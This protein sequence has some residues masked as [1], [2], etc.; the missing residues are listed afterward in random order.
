MIDDV[1]RV[2]QVVLNKN[3]YGNIDPDDMNALAKDAQLKVFYDLPSEIYRIKRRRSTTGI[4]DALVPFQNALDVF[5]DREPVQRES[6]QDSSTGFSDYFV[7]PLD[8][9]HLESVWYRDNTFVDEIDKKKGR[10]VLSNPNTAPTVQY[11]VFEKRGNNI[12]LFPET[13]GLTISNGGSII[14]SDV[15]IYY[16]R[17]PK[18]PKWTFISVNNKAVF[19][20]GDSSYQDFELPE[21][22]FRRLL[23]EMAFLSGISLREEEVAKYMNQEQVDDVQKQNLN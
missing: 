17:K 13:I 21:Y 18:D 10:F 14:N 2:M 23:V 4:K 7:L 12:Y 22:F 15:S 6:V 11:P 1:Y 20:P 19:N 16:R 3:N 9:Y 5:T 8:F